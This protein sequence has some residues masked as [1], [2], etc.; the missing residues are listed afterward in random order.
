[1]IEILDIIFV[2]YFYFHLDVLSLVLVM[3]RILF[4]QWALE[5]IIRIYGNTE[6][7]QLILSLV[8]TAKVEFKSL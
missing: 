4:E 1:M 5:E 2:L 8:D 6:N 3:P 7:H